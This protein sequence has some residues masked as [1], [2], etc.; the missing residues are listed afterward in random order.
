[1][2]GEHN[3]QIHPRLRRLFSKYGCQR[4]AGRVF[5]IPSKR[6]KGG[7]WSRGC[8]AFDGFGGFDGSGGFLPAAMTAGIGP[9]KQDWCGDTP[10][11]QHPPPWRHPDSQVQNFAAILSQVW[12]LRCLGARD[13]NQDPLANRFARIESCNLK[14]P[15]HLK[16]V[17][18]SLGPANNHPWI[19]TTLGCP[20]TPD[21]RNSSVE[22]F[23]S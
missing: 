23:P 18:T 14:N 8:V 1:M 3:L 16:K 2:T 15:K 7:V 4:G 6:C 13:S 22:K 12:G 19:L 9:R 5:Q 11:K 20:G 17:K 21:P 10:P